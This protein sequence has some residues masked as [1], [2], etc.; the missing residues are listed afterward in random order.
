MSKQKTWLANGLCILT[1][2]TSHT[3]APEIIPSPRSTLPSAETP[4]L[5][6]TG[7]WTFTTSSQIHRYRSRSITTINETP[8][9]KSRADTI[10]LDTY[11]TI[12][13]SPLHSTTTIAG[14]IDSLLLSSNAKIPV[15][16]SRIRLP[17]PFTGNLA[18]KV[19]ILRPSESQPECASPVTTI[20][21]EIRPVIFLHPSPI[22]SN[23]TWK[24]S[25]STATCSSTQIPTTVE[26]A[27]SY[28]VSGRT[29]YGI[30]QALVIERTDSTHFVG[31]GMQDQHQVD[32]TGIGVGL[33]NIYLDINTGTLALTDTRAITSITVRISGQE[34]RFTQE[35][36]QRVD[37]IP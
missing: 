7:S 1:A 24:D 27:S 13:L 31:H 29:R 21:G 36:T 18:D 3:P 37:L 28:Q 11:F 10:R 6:S 23:S 33:T 2:C 17:I 16:Q 9:R 35:V 20:L 12:S 8:A 25:L 15:N 32:I 14:Q 30:I 34:R 22:F 5:E 19:L 4:P 26:L